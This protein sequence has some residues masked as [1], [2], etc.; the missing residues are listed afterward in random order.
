M[1]IP[2]VSTQERERVTSLK[3]RLPRGSSRPRSLRGTPTSWDEGGGKRDTTHSF[4]KA[5]LKV[6]LS[7][8]RIHQLRAKTVLYRYLLTTVMT[9]HSQP[10]TPNHATTHTHT[11][12]RT[13]RQPAAAK[14]LGSG[15]GMS[16]GRE[17]RL[18]TAVTGYL[19][20]LGLEQSPVQPAPRTPK[21][22]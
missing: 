3:I 22:S 5:T 19:S 17:R 10:Y 9:L 14:R 6:S 15:T 2:W 21:Y 8:E 18:I 16:R 7:M 13:A 4:L 12:T 1:G 11:H 20:L